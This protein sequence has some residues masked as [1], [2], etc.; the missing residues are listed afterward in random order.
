MFGIIAV[1]LSV[2]VILAGLSMLAKSKKESLGKLYTFSSYAAI[3]I[4]LGLFIGGNIGGM[5]RLLHANCGSCSSSYGPKGHGSCASFAGHQGSSCRSH[6]SS[7]HGSYGHGSVCGHGGQSSY[8]HGGKSSCSSAGHSGNGH[9]SCAQSSC[10]HGGKK[11]KTCK[12]HSHSGVNGENIEIKVE[13]EEDD[14]DDDEDDED[15]EDE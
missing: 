5:K 6:A 3:F 10:D 7:G 9:G 2:L 15:D 11:H 1:S 13:I 14:D 4:G 12:K 8:N